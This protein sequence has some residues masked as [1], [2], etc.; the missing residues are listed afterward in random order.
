M[1]GE[2]DLAESGRSAAYEELRAAFAV[3]LL[4]VRGGAPGPAPEPYADELLARWAEPQRK[5]HT[6]DHL[7]AVLRH[8]DTLTGEV[9]R[10]AA[11]GTAAERAWAGTVRDPDAVRLAAWFHDA[12]YRP[13]RSE[14]EERSAT[15]AERALRE[16]GLASGPVAEVARLVR[17]TID[18][19]TAPGDGDGELLCDADLAVLAGVPEEYAAYAAAV[20]E[21]Y[22]FL[23]EEQFRHGRA[24]VL[25]H[26]LALPRLFRTPYGSRHWEQRA[27][28][29]LTTELTLLG[30]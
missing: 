12:V 13:D 4:R 30:G 5:Y 24:E 22:G 14:N 27:R 29:N 17:L 6:V 18:H 26:L 7:R 9:A 28:E 25:R 19:E 21:E 20:S 3:T 1:D 15:L 10:A 8:L 23:P 16:A 11:H 2:R